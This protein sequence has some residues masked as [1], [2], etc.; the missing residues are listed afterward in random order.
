MTDKL[1]GL[2]ENTNEEYHS[3]PG[4]SKSMLDSIS[5]SPLN[6][7]DQY[8]NPDRE[9]REF[10]RAFAFGDGTHKIVLEPGTFE[11]SYIVGFDKTAYPDALNTADDMK[12]A[13]SKRNAMT[14]GSKPELARRLVEEEGFSRSDILMYLEEDHKASY[15]NKQEIPA[16]DYKDIMAMLKNINSHHT[17]AGLLKDASVEQSFYWTDQAGILRKCRTDAISACGRFVL[18]LKTTDFDVSAAGF[19][20]TVMQRRYHVQAA[21]YLDVLRGLYGAGAPQTFVFIVAQKKRPYDVSVQFLSAEQVE[22]GRILY[23]N[24][25]ERLIQC[26]QADYWP[27]ADGGAIL[28]AELPLWH[29]NQVLGS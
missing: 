3:G 21:W 6:F 18:D 10:K 9:E 16:S 24:D 8:I 4:I 29:T 20:R 13:L 11:E 19:G 17:A 23:Q 26:Q 25:Y 28:Q 7:W 12:Q 15:G 2:V 5:I 27:G 14:G 1:Q 22:V